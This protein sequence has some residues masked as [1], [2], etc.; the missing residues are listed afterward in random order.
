MDDL[1]V[2][3]YSLTMN[4][5]WS[6][7]SMGL[8]SVASLLAV[9]HFSKRL[10]FSEQEGLTWVSIGTQK[11]EGGLCLS[12]SAGHIPVLPVPLIVP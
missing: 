2:H 9:L 12:S 3:Y 6:G 10:E 8:L 5:V 1:Q 11:A 7:L 4:L